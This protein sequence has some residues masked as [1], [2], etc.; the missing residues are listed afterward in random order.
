MTTESL[1][2]R[3]AANDP[4]GAHAVVGGELQVRTRAVKDILWDLADASIRE[5]RRI[6]EENFG[7]CIVFEHVNHETGSRAFASWLILEPEREDR[8]HLVELV[9][10]VRRRHG[11][12]I[13]WHGS[14]AGVLISKHALARCAQRT[15]HI[16]DLER[17]V[18]AIHLHVARVLCIKA[19]EYL[20]AGTELQTATEDGVVL[21]RAEETDE[22][23]MLVASTWLDGDTLKD[24]ELKDL[25]ARSRNPSGQ[26]LVRRGPLNSPKEKSRD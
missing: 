21:W 17:L 12:D 3:L 16:G 10:D 6:L 14:S 19:D 23:N 13:P 2:Q 7:G 8:L 1:S 25:V 5:G 4:G 9:Y 26:V 22:G 24:P 15:V 11:K 18:P 20:L